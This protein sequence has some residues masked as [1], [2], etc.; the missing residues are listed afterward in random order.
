VFEF[1]QNLDPRIAESAVVGFPHDIYGEGETNLTN[2]L[3][4]LIISCTTGVFAFLILKN[5]VTDD[6]KVI[7]EDLMKLVRKMIAAF[8][9]P[10][11]F[12]VC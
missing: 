8:A 3:C 12:L 9:V 1:F 2:Y 11:V 4:M 7:F 6:E 5:G 10:N